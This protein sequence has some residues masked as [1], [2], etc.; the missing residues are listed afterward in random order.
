[1]ATPANLTASDI[2]TRVMNQLRMPTTNTTELAKIRALLNEVYRDIA[3]KYDFWFLWKRTA[4]NTVDDYSTGTVNVTAASTSVTLSSAPSTSVGSTGSFANSMFY[5]TGNAVDPGALFR[6]ESHTAGATSIVI[7]AGY[8]G[9]T[10][11]AA[12]YRLW[13]DT[14][15]LPADVM[16][17]MKVKRYGWRDALLKLG[18]AEM[19]DLKTRDSSRTGAPQAWTVMDFVTTG[20][21]TTRRSLVVH[22][23]PDATYR[24]EIFY[25][26]Q[27]NTEI[28]STTQP[29]MPDEYRQILVYG[30]LARGYPIF[31]SD[32]ERGQ[33]FQ[34]LFNDML[35]LM[36]AAHREYAQDYPR[37][38]PRGYER[39]QSRRA[40]RGT[41]GNLFDVLPRDY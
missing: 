41:L 36:T 22:P 10:A 6:V 37:I 3:I 39:S 12:S 31:L 5:V 21:P 15:S 24:L 35:N 25:K 7:D 13:T 20:D 8:T 30:A 19:A 26:Q 16:K 27:L 9:A 28:S 1:M 2:E 18:P 14:Y 23:M 40:R 38:E 17:V 4:I 33:F 34:G 11:T 29:L 32:T